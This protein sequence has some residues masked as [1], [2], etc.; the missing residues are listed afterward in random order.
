MAWLLA[1]R[2]PGFADVFAPVNGAYWMNA[3][4]KCKAGAPLVHSHER[5]SKFWPLKGV[6]GHRKLFAR[7]AVKD[8][9][10]AMALGNGCL[11]SKKVDGAIPPGVVHTR[12]VKCRS[13]SGLDLLLLKERF[14]MPEW[15]LDQVL[16][17]TGRPEPA[18]SDE[19]EKPIAR[20]RFGKVPFGEKPR[21]KSRED[22]GA[23]GR[24][25]ARPPG[26]D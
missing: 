3:P 13:G 23:A 5:N 16:G 4:K 7:T 17:A 2:S 11:G 14:D 20:P 18:V 10:A 25:V 8:N 15:W 22:G 26:S 24:N 21:F 12:W 6:K 9:L 1:C 19:P